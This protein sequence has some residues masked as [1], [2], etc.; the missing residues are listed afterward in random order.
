MRYFNLFPLLL[1]CPS[2]IAKESIWDIYADTTNSKE[3][4]WLIDIENDAFIDSDRFFTNAFRVTRAFSSKTYISVNGEKSAFFT[5]DGNIQEIGDPLP[6]EVKEPERA[7]CKEKPQSAYDFHYRVNVLD[8]IR[9]ENEFEIY[10]HNA[11]WQA[12]N[13]IY[14]PKVITARFEQFE[15]LDR[16]YAGY[17]YYSRFVE[18]LYADDSRTRY[19]LQLGLLGRASFSE[20]VQKNWHKLWS[21]DDPTWEKQIATKP[22]VQVNYTH[23]FA[24][25]QFMKWDK[26]VLLNTRYTDAQPYVIIEAGT[27]F[28]RATAGLDIRVSLYNMK[29]YFAGPLLVPHVP[30]LDEQNLTSAPEPKPEIDVQS[31]LC[32]FQVICAPAS[33]YLFATL[34][35]TAVLRNSTIEGGVFTDS[36]YTL[37]AA[38]R[39]RTKAVGVKVSW[40]TWWITGTYRVRSPEVEGIPFDDEY[41]RWGEFQFGFNW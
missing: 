18:S 22:A 27:V 8:C 14:T 33:A 5:E 9:G 23:R 34:E 15:P 21:L 38:K 24:I 30:E 31:T 41:H 1:L 2:A 26:D 19:E 10:K 35:E 6:I 17:T 20:E 25:P 37:H 29:S 11:G 39:V 36:P 40:E 7:D 4:A 13:L 28:M 3:S 16:P 32:T 12:A